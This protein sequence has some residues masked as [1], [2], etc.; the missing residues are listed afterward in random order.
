MIGSVLP[1]FG[2]LSVTYIYSSFYRQNRSPSPDIDLKR[3]FEQEVKSVKSGRQFK[4]LVQ[5]GPNKYKC[6]ICEY[7]VTGKRELM[8]HFNSDRHKRYVEFDTFFWP[9]AVS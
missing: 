5:V 1:S 8:R 4:L 6:M 9:R 3:Y 2:I 7:T